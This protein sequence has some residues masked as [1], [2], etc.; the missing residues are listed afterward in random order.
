MDVAGAR[1]LENHGGVP[2]HAGHRGHSPCRI[3]PEV[4]RVSSVTFRLRVPQ[5]SYR[6]FRNAATAESIQYKFLKLSASYIW[7]HLQRAFNRAMLVALRKK[8]SMYNLSN[9]VTVA[10][11]CDSQLLI[12][13]KQLKVR[14]SLE[15]HR[16]R[17]KTTHALTLILTRHW[18]SRH[19]ESR[20]G[21]ARLVARQPPV[22]HRQGP[23]GDGEGE[24]D[25]AA[26]CHQH[27][28]DV[29]LG[30]S[31][32]STFRRFRFIP[33]YLAVPTKTLKSS[34]RLPRCLC[35]VSA[36]QGRT[37]RQFVTF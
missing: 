20:C 10:A 29:L 5:F 12:S 23:P 14:L 9:T 18:Y 37:G 11:L 22:G 32:Q 25:G 15:S 27:S 17:L 7:T 33:T 34:R 3:N 4:G 26:S 36:G 30:Q 28:C 16:L 2:S 31:S 35:V 24:T 21:V 13:G 8:V 19:S 1:D 6:Q